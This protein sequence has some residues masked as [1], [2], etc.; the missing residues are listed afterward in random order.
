MRF[1]AI[2]GPS[3]SPAGGRISL[4]MDFLLMDSLHRATLDHIG[5]DFTSITSS[6]YGEATSDDFGD[7]ESRNCSAIYD[8]Y[9]VSL[10]G[11]TVL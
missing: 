5:W 1:R 11:L 3:K 10:V 8:R 7:E 2:L 4:L 6:C 9:S